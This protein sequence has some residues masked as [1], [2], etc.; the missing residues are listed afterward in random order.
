MAAIDVVL[1]RG[2]TVAM[3]MEFAAAMV[4]R[5]ARAP[6][7]VPKLKEI[8]VEVPIASLLPK[9]SSCGGRAS[10]MDKVGRNPGGQIATAR[11]PLAGKARSR[12]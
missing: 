10:S 2:V 12:A 6:I 4:A 3:R 11:Y 1:A 7:I 9:A 5:L 8:S